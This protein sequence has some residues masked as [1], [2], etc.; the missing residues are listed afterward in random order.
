ML[1]L[2]DEKVRAS[3]G[4]AFDG[5]GGSLAVDGDTVIVG[6]AATALAGPLSGSAYAIDVSP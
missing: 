4:K 3:D 1:W 5:F 2:E 6:A